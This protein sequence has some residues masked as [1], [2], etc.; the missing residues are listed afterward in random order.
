MTVMEYFER[1]QDMKKWRRVFGSDCRESD[2]EC[3]QDSQTH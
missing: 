1:R 3:R 2:S